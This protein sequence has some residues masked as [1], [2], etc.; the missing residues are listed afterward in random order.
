MLI[1]RD[2]VLVK[3]ITVARFLVFATVT[4][5]NARFLVFATVTVMNARFL[6]FATVTVMNAVFWDIQTQFVSQQ[7]THYVS[8]TEPSRL[9]LCN[10]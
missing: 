3:S 9:M 6:V 1:A 8:T 5:M 10:I 2:R 7:E 4:M